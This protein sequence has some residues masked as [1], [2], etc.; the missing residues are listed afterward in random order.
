M[1]QPVA[2]RNPNMFTGES[3]AAFARRM[4]YAPGT[5]LVGNEGY[6]DTYLTITGLGEERI[7]ARAWTERHGHGYEKLWTLRYRD[8]Q[9]VDALPAEAEKRDA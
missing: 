9:Q 2:N 7:L 6:G 5:V 1:T 3:S 8:W 4:G